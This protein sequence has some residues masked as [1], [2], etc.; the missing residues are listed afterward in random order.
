MNFTDLRFTVITSNIVCSIV[1]SLSATHLPSLRFEVYVHH[2]LRVQRHEGVNVL[3]GE[4]DHFWCSAISLSAR[5]VEWNGK[6]CTCKLSAESNGFIGRIP[7][8]TESLRSLRL[9]AYTNSATLHF[10]DSTQQGGM[11]YETVSHRAFY[12]TI[13][14]RCQLYSCREFLKLLI[15]EVFIVAYYLVTKVDA[16]F[17][18]LLI[19]FLRYIEDVCSDVYLDCVSFVEDVKSCDFL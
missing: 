16:V 1:G 18:C 8:A 13:N 19:W 6:S 4:C 11:I 12:S 14:N 2:T 9:R 15:Q 7:E 10:V 5:I 3:L 17:F